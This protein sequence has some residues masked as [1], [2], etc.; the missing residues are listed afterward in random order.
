M[1]ALAL[2]EM[3]PYAVFLYGV[4]DYEMSRGIGAVRRYDSDIA[5]NYS[6]NRYVKLF[7]GVKVMGTRSI[8]VPITARSGS[9]PGRYASA[10]GQ[11]FLSSATY[12]VCMD[13]AGR[14]MTR[15]CP[16]PRARR[17]QP[18]LAL[19]Y[20]IEPASTTIT[21]GGRYQWFSIKYENDDPDEYADS[22]ITFYGV[23]FSVVYSFEL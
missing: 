7:G 3:E 20:Y 1:L 4:Y 17:V 5:L 13:S 11:L 18:T 19:A 22:R 16:R 2:P 15:A 23:T 21:L 8:P 12:P 6:I 10:F 14:S 9:R